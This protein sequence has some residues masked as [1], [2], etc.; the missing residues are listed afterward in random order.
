VAVAGAKPRPGRC[1]QGDS[2]W[3]KLTQPMRPPLYASPPF[4]KTPAAGA[5]RTFRQ[6][7][8]SAHD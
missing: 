8:P 7:T 6:I 3:D 2:Q 1:D 5:G 4:R